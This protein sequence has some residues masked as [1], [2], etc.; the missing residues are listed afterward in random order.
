MPEL[1]RAELSAVHED[2]DGVVSTGNNLSVHEGAEPYNSQFTIHNSQLGDAG[3]PFRVIG[4]ALKTYIVAEY[5]GS[6][7]FIDKHAAH[8]RIHFDALKD[9]EQK[10]MS[11]ALITPVIC[12][13]G[14]EDVS[15]LLDNAEFLEEL[16]FLVD[17]FGEGAVA[18]RSIPAEIDITDAEPTLSE[19]CAQLRV[20]G[21]ISSVHRDEIYSTLACKAAIKSG[22]SSDFQE[23]EALAA[24][25]FSGEVAQC[26]HGRP[27]AF[28]VTKSMLE[29]WFKRS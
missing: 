3:S 4:E 22:K 18:V 27:V 28:E 21:K 20:G 10:Q 2:D 23:L 12:R 16:G 19:I 26:P 13:L 24:R 15:T 29:R 5:Q 17:S 8:E 25:V 9:S 7:W 14:Q 11:Q 6:V 1:A